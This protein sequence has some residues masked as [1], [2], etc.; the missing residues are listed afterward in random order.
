MKDC[1][2]NHFESDGKVIKLL[3]HKF[4][5]GKTWG[6]DG[7]YTELK[8]ETCTYE[9]AIDNYSN[10]IMDYYTQFSDAELIDEGMKIR[11]TCNE[12]IIKTLLE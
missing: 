10:R 2:G 6:P 8:C 11:I 3:G 12:Y 4:I 7:D 5:I 1:L 9:A